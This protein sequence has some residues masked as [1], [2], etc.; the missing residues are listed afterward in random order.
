M[1]RAVAIV[2]ALGLLLGPVAARAELD[3]PKLPWGNDFGCRPTAAHPR[4]VV[5]LHG[6]GSRAELNWWV[7]GPKLAAAGFCVFA[8]TDGIDPRT[9]GLVKAL[10]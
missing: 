7:I 5:L 9:R 10:S 4:P 1:R 3:V 6:L 2:V 8:P